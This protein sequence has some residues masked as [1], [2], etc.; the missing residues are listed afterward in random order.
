MKATTNDSSAA[1]G[2]SALTA[3]LA[4]FV[5]QACSMSRHNKQAVR[6]ENE[7]GCYFCI[8]SFPSSA[9]VEFADRNADTALCPNCG[10]D[11]VLPGVTDKAILSTAHERWFCE[12]ANDRVEGPRADLSREVRSHD[13]LEG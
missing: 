4:V 1:C 6:D 8:R 5:E 11:S 10:I 7:C 13:G 9:V 2:Q 12:T 3:G